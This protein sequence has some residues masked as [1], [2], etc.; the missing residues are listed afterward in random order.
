[1]HNYPD[2]PHSA[3][4]QPDNSAPRPLRSAD[5]VQVHVQSFTGNGAVSYLTPTVEPIN[6]SGQRADLPPQIA[7]MRWNWGA[8]LFTWLWCFF[9]GVPVWGVIIIGLALLRLYVDLIH[10]EFG[11]LISLPISVILFLIHLYLGCNGNQLAWRNR[12]FVNGYAEFKKV[13]WIWTQWGVGALLTSCPFIVSYCI[14]SGLKTLGNHSIIEQP[15]AQTVTI[16]PP[17]TYAPAQQPV[18]SPTP[19]IIRYFPQ[20]RPGTYRPTNSFN[21]G[22]YLPQNGPGPNGDPN[23]WVRRQGS[24]NFDPYTQD[25]RS[26]APLSNNSSQMDQSINSSQ[27]PVSNGYQSTPSFNTSANSPVDSSRTN[28]GQISTPNTGNTPQAINNPSESTQGN[29]TLQSTT[30]N[31]TGGVQPGSNP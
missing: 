3:P 2:D 7:Y 27:P 10:L 24:E 19:P 31:T 28:Q 26:T 11:V 4:N 22:R 23:A 12:R 25:D 1:L 21:G 8:F 9:N 13:Q 30:T 20:N 5:P 16:A 6:T 14:W 18:F 29:G 15:T 17:Q